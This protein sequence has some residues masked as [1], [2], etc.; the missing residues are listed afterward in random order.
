MSIFRRK[1]SSKNLNSTSAPSS[2]SQ[3]GDQS[4]PLPPKDRRA[5]SAQ[6]PS[7]DSQR[8][9]VDDF[10]RPVGEDRPAF[11]RELNGAGPSRPFGAGYGV[12]EDEPAAGAE[13]QLLFGY[14]P[15]ETTVE[16]PVQR[17]EELVNKVATEIRTRGE[18]IVWEAPPSCSGS[19]QACRRRRSSN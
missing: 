19:C 5:S 12:G 14:T 10:G 3:R 11:G 6:V 16:L 13:M 17:V 7:S 4:P 8:L 1:K 9:Y 15:L 18:L 2:P